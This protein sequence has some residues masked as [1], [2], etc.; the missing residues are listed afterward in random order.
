MELDLDRIR[1][2]LAAPIR[3]N[4]GARAS[5]EALRFQTTLLIEQYE[6]EVSRDG[7]AFGRKL[8]EALDERVVRA[9]DGHAELSDD[10]STVSCSAT[11]V[12]GR[13]FVD[14]R[15]EVKCL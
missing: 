14:I 8:L 4:A 9:V 12:R 6:R 3:D 2:I 15:L 1:E 13:V 11:I 5:L 10:V 7:G